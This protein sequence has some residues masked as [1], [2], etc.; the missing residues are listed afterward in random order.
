MVSCFVLVGNSQ[1]CIFIMPE[2]RSDPRKNDYG[3]NALAI[4]LPGLLP[5]F[6]EL[7]HTVIQSMSVIGFSQP[8]IAGEQQ[9]VPTDK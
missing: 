3:P 6:V 7:H 1:L 5:R 9:L 4:A 2:L 8:R